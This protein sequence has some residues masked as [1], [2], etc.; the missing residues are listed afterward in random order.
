M[1]RAERRAQWSEEKGLGSNL[2]RPEHKA[3]A[4]AKG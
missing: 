4:P 1:G 2:E 3:A